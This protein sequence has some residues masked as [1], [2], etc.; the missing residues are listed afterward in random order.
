MLRNL[1]RVRPLLARTGQKLLHTVTKDQLSVALSASKVGRL[2]A[3][4][5]DDKDP[6]QQ[7]NHLHQPGFGRFDRKK[8]PLKPKTES[9]TPA[10]ESKDDLEAQ[11]RE[12]EEKLALKLKEIEEQKKLID[13][14]NKELNSL[15]DTVKKTVEDKQKSTDDIEFWKNKKVGIVDMRRHRTHPRRSA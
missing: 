8:S 9:T 2:A 6:K 5:G 13:A 7:G 12:I 15:E 14:M 3:R 4:F 10:S 11:K 1:D